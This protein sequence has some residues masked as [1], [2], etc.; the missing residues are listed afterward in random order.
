[1]NDPAEL[2]RIA[3]KWVIDQKPRGT[4]TI[5]AD[6]I[7]I[8]KSHLNDYLRRG[9]PFPEIYR[10][11]IAELFGYKY[12][13]M[14]SMGRRLQAGENIDISQPNSYQEPEAVNAKTQLDLVIDTALMTDIITAIEKFIDQE[15]L[16]LEPAEK[17]RLIALQYELYLETGKEVSVDN[18]KRHL[19]LVA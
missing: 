8:A 9:K 1:M 18:V 6:K 13:E 3:L 12:E 7:N 17:A 16:K 14:I 10:D 19:R 5:L 4:Q 2:Y 15:D 11:Q